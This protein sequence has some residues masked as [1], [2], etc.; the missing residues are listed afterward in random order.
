LVQSVVIPEDIDQAVDRWLVGASVD[1]ENRIRGEAREDNNIRFSPTQLQVSGATG[2]CR[3][4]NNE[5]NDSRGEAVPVAV[6]GINDLGACGNVDWFSVD[7]PPNSLLSVTVSEDTMTNSI[8]MRLVDAAGQSLAE[9]SRGSSRLNAFAITSEM[10][11]VVF[12]EVSAGIP[13]VAYDLGL[14]IADR[15]IEGHLKA[16]NIAVSPTVAQA[17]QAVQVSGRILNA[18][19]AT[20]LPTEVGFFVSSTPGSLG[21]TFLEGVELEQLEA[22]ASETFS[23]NVTLPPVLEDGA[24]FITAKPDVGGVTNSSLADDEAWDLLV[25]D[26][27][28]A[29]TADTLEPNQS[30]HVNDGQGSGIVERVQPGDYEDLWVCNTDDDWYAVELEAGQRLSASVSYTVSD[31][32]VELSL[33]GSDGRTVLDESA[34]LLGVENVELSRVTQSGVYFLR[35]FLKTGSPRRENSYSLSLAVGDADACPDDTYEPN[36][37]R[38]SAPLLRDGTHDLF[39]CESDQ[40]WYR[41]AIAAGN[42]VSWQLTSGDAPLRMFLYDESGLVG[43]S[44]RR[45]VHQA[46]RNGTHYLQVVADVPGEYAYQIRSSG[47][48][49]VDLALGSISS[50]RASVTPGSGFRISG[51]V[52]NRRGDFATNVLVQ[53]YL[54]STPEDYESGILLG[55][56]TVSRIDGAGVEAFSMRVQAPGQQS[57]NMLG[58][59]SPGE[60]HITAVV[61]P[62]RS[63]PDAQFSNNVLSTDISFVQG[64]VDDD[65]NDNEGP[66]TASQLGALSLI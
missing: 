53:S 46:R 31:G 22:G 33:Y 24:Y 3:E 32:D 20:V 26:E 27:Q 43:E 6:P 65:P 11:D 37:E 63:V 29:C 49:G 41:F 21:A 36:G 7:V 38:M 40:D 15:G 35:V 61:D 52:E 66:T 9:A 10:P 30:P 54:S 19:T 59:S 4:D 57:L 23:V 34:S 1:P 58:I 17:G 47:V 14:T 5:P 39:L 28:G 64:C 48:S 18:G 45:I 50:S 42:T 56:T 62:D 8:R 12:I 16:Q 55:E 60:G 51:Q 13:E 44:D 2:G 25:V